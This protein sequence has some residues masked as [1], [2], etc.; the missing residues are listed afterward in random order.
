[1]RDTI[2][3]EIVDADS[4]GNA[5]VQ[6]FVSS[7]ITVLNQSPASDGAEDQMLVLFLDHSTNTRKTKRTQKKASNGTREVI[8]EETSMNGDIE[9]S[10]IKYLS[11]N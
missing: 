1:M 9:I 8:T 4:H 3:M 6:D 10:S 7:S 5:K 2:G 11:D